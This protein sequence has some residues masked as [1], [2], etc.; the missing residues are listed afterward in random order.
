VNPGAD[1]WINGAGTSPTLV[2]TAGNIL[3]EI[4]GD[5]LSSALGSVD[6]VELAKGTKLV[7]VG[8]G[9]DATWSKQAMVWDVTDLEDIWLYAYGELVLD[10]FNANTNG[11]GVVSL[12]LHNDGTWNLFQCLSNNGLANYSLEEWVAPELITIAEARYDRN[13]APELLG[14]VV[15]VEGVLTT[16]NFQP[17]ANTD[18]F[19]QDETAGIKLFKYGPIELA[20]GWKMRVTG[21][22]QQYRGVTEIVPANDAAIVPITADN[23][24]EIKTVL[25]SAVGEDLEGSMLRLNDVWVVDRSKWPPTG[26]N[27]GSVYVTDGSDTVQVYI[28]KDT[29]IDGWT[30]PMFFDVIGPL[31]QYSTATPPNNGYEL[32]P[33]FQ[34]DFIPK[35]EALMSLEHT[36]GDLTFGIFNDG[37]I[38]AENVVST[39]SGPGINWKGQNGA[40]LGSVIFGSKARGMVNGHLGSFKSL[41]PTTVGDLVN[42][43][44]A[45]VNGFTSDDNFD[46]IAVA[47]LSDAGAPNPYGVDIV[48]YTASNTGEEF[49]LLGY[50]FINRTSTTIKDFYAGVFIDF[51]VDANTYQTNS[52]GYDFKNRIV[53]VYDKTSPSYYGIVGLN[54]VTGM[55]LSNIWSGYVDGN[56]VRTASFEYISTIDATP[57][58]SETDLRAWIGSKLDNLAPGDTVW[59]NFGLVA[60]DD[61]A[62]LQANAEAALAKAAALGWGEVSIDEPP[63]VEIPDEYSLSNN[64]P[65]PFNPTTNISYALPFDSNVQVTIYNML[66]E[67]VAELVNTIQPAGHY[68]INWNAGDKAS[69]IYFFAIKARSADGQHTFQKVNKMMLVK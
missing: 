62:G 1:I 9:N 20:I 28:D 35:P 65:N 4:G 6:Y 46:Q 25:L 68:Q 54:W 12:A 18:Y 41:D 36:P 69:G 43:N 66:G 58:P 45:F 8:G 59:I 52:G 23:D 48:Q 67:V 57:P 56:G 51:D 34:E 7:A 38:A 15:T 13:F 55:R 42:V 32:R 64:Y 19:I 24:F 44:S 39:G 30:P 22:I 63:V 17:G 50:G 49:G 31:D 26:S 29:D 33:R 16:P 61:L 2:D 3:A 60:G 21:Q 40:Y 14:D 27:G 5:L 11:T 47:V 37:S 10:T 53:Y